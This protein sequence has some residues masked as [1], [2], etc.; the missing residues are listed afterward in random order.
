MKQVE[1]LNQIELDGEVKIVMFST[2]VCGVCKMLEPT[3]KNFLKDTGVEAFKIDATIDLESAEKF[4]IKSVPYTL[5]YKG[6]EIVEEFLGFK[7]QRMLE[8]LIN[9][10][11]KG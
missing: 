7:S 5:V 10:Y 1:K 8:N 11:I 2:P 4:E 3:I 9:P 6:N